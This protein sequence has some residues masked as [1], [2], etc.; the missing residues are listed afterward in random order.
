MT[1][2]HGLASLCEPSQAGGVRLD[3]KDSFISWCLFFP[4]VAILGPLGISRRPFHSFMLC[5][6]VSMIGG[7][8]VECIE[9]LQRR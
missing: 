7:G 6:C 5:C 8:S 9:L 3:V 2:Y 4:E 1:V